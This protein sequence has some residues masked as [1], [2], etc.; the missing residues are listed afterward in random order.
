MKDPY[1]QQGEI[2]DHINSAQKWDVYLG[3]RT[4]FFYPAGAL[5]ELVSILLALRVA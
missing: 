3:R 5:W 4:I 2:E 1:T